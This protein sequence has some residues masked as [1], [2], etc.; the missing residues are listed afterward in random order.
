MTYN[1]SQGKAGEEYGLRYFMK[2]GY[3]VILKNYKTRFGEIDLVLK[4]GSKILFI[5]F[6]T[7]TSKNTDYIVEAWLKKQLKNMVFVIKTLICK[8]VINAEMEFRIELVII[9][10][11]NWPEINLHRKVYTLQNNE[12]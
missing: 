9:D 4:K 11:A 5:E 12:F 6:K 3:K 2:R 8:K 7:T 1:L 10:L